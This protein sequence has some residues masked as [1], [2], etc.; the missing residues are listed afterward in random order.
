MSALYSAGG[1]SAEPY[2]SRHILRFAFGLVLMLSIALVDIRFIARLSW[3]GLCGR[4]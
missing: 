2:A 4:R 3:L 1:G